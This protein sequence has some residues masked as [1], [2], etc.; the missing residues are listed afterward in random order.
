MEASRNEEEERG[1]ERNRRRTTTYRRLYSVVGDDELL[2]QPVRP[3]HRGRVPVVLRPVVAQLDRVRP[4]TRHPELLYRLVLLGLRHPPVLDDVSRVVRDAL[5]HPTPDTGGHDEALARVEK[6]VRF[7]GEGHRNEK[8]LR[9]RE[10]REEFFSSSLSFSGFAVVA[11]ASEKN[12][13]V[14]FFRTTY[15][16]FSFPGPE[17]AE[18]S[19][20][21]TLRW[22][23]R[24]KNQRAR[25]E[26]RSEKTTTNV[27]KK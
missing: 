2:F 7:R 22:G 15:L 6:D 5:D 25:G 18:N 1:K 10:S 11:D 24:G 16:V 4:G 8:S 21:S 19:E 27:E 14:V 12:K 17:R 23:F 9:E 20:G 3:V 26:R 13:L